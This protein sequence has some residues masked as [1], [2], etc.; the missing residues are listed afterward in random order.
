MSFEDLFLHLPE[1]RVVICKRCRYAPVPAQIRRHLKD[2]HP[3]VSARQRGEIALTVQSLP[4]LARRPQD[5][6]YP[7]ASRS[8]IE[9]L[10]VLFNCLRCQGREPSGRRCRYACRAVKRMQRHCKKEHR[11]VNEQRRGGDSRSKQQH[12]PNK[13]WECGRACQRFFKVGSWQRY[14]EVEAVPS[15]NR[16][17][18]VT[19][20]HTTFF[21]QQ[22]EDIQQARDDAAEAANLVEGFDSHRSAVLPWLQTTGIADHVGGLKKG[23]ISAAITVTVSDGEE[24]L[25]RM[26]EAMEGMLRKAH[27]YCFDGPDCM[28]TWQCRVVLSRFQSAQVE[29]IGKTRPW[30][31]YKNAAT[32][33]KYFQPAKQLL[34]YVCRVAANREYYF[35]ADAVGG[36]RPEDTMSLTP[37]QARMWRSVRRLARD[38]EGASDS[39]AGSALQ[40]SLLELWMLFICDVTGAQRYRSPLVS[41]CAM[42]SIKQSTA[43]WMEPGNFSSHLSAVIWVVQ[44]LIFYDSARKE[45]QGDGRTL[46][47]V[48]RCCEDYLQQTVET[49]MGEI[50]RWRLLLF[51]VAQ[52]TVG[53]RQ[54]T[55]NEAEDVVS[56]EG[57]DIHMDDIPQL[58]KL[59]HDDCQRLLRED[60]MFGSTDCPRMHAYALKDDPD[61]ESVGWDFTRHRDNSTWLDGRERKLL[62]TIEGSETLRGLFLV[63]DE[64]A[65]AGIAWR[66]SALAAYESTVQDFLQRLCTLIHISGGQPVREPE[67]FAMTWCN[68]Q[69][70]RRIT[71]RHER[72]MIHLQ[73]HKGQQQTGNFKENIRFLAHPVSDLLL[74]YL[75]YVQPLR[76]IF[77]RQ[78]SPKGLLS[79]YLFEKGGKAW[80]DGK[81][82]RC[83]ERSSTRAGIARLHVSNWRQ[84]TVAIVKTKFAG[85]IAHFEEDPDDEDAEEVDNEVRI[86]T[87][88]RNHKT[89]TVNRA[90]ANQ[91]AS[92]FGNVWDGLLRMNLRASILWQD[93]W[94]VDIVLGDRKRRREEGTESRLSKRIASGIHRPRRPWSSTALLEGLR[95]LYND[96]SMGWRSVE[97][98]QTL[99][100]TMCWTEQVVAILPTG[101]GKSVSF[102]LPCTLPGAGV[103]V[104]VVPL[105]ALRADMLQRLDQLHIAYLEWAPGERSEA[106]LVV[107]SAEAAGKPDFRK[108]ATGLQEQQKLDRIVVDECHLTV[109]A[110]SYRPSLVDLTTI[111]G[112]RTQFVYLTATL[113]PSMLAEFEE[114]NYLHRPTII[115]ASSNRPNI[116]YAVEVARSQ[117]RTLLEQAA[118][119]ARAEWERSGRFDHS[120][121]KIIL[122]VR[123]VADAEALAGLLGCESYT[124]QSGAFEERKAILDRWTR[125]P[126]RPYVVA[127]SA[128]AEGF[129]DPHVR[130]VV[131]VGEPESLVV[132][133]QES[134]RAGRDGQKAYSLVL[135]P[136]GWKPSG[137][138]RPSLDD[139][140]SARDDGS[141]AKLRDRRAVH[142][143]LRGN[144]CHRTTLTERLDAVHHRRWCMMEDVACAVC[145]RSHE[146]VVPPQVGEEQGSRYTGLEMIRKDRLRAQTELSQYQRGLVN[147]KGNCPLCRGLGERWDH[148]FA[149]CHRRHQVFRARDDA[150]RRHKELGTK[151]IQPYTA[152]FRCFQPQVICKR[153]DPERAG[154]RQRECEHRDIVLPLC[155]GIFH[156]V[157]GQVWV[158]EQFGRQFTDLGKYVDWLGEESRLGNERATQGARVVAR[159][160]QEYAGGDT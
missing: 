73:Y 146:E 38:T 104:L 71:I 15:S 25:E 158:K 56:F 142:E 138:E 75:V 45:Q 159:K 11:W 95:R 149:T 127:T 155:L 125:D 154:E 22:E 74:D 13:A 135:L 61:V 52:N 43:S 39:E 134:G 35:T 46:A 21:R 114:R 9:G 113:P 59:D 148:H 50:L 79:G 132:F 93:F 157:D 77:L 41:F 126:L 108:Y 47:H 102:M 72:V 80:P 67:F 143:Y 24:Y 19:E 116:R 83:L 3:K 2:H 153:A 111:R 100:A 152:C 58:L 120:C 34:A 145:G 48:K 14:F 136:A 101:A 31:P 160:M 140:V 112:I 7:P 20:Q 89:R 69:R 141:L 97:Q 12:A 8:P 94:G 84:M 66:E 106:P 60:L 105:V 91:T 5:V 147:M 129:D 144:Q 63:Q 121:D 1:S 42:H 122:Y 26:F 62:S 86:M 156:S 53:E 118:D 81:L 33:R 27:S 51:H 117:R 23:E 57:T 133:A 107:V 68:T 18:Q 151:W 44:L 109:T 78:S 49:P 96:E 4:D 123:A 37:E 10:N 119:R 70:R 85:H 32:L 36:R 137:F 103:T 99:V 92:T 54:A 131:N 110:A 55:W 128:L 40:E 87:R 98:E 30:E 17:R 88:Q 6:V 90:Y 16:P 29:T 64:Q 82:T 139:N 65:A 28:L 130:F 150:A 76:Q 124:A 115:R